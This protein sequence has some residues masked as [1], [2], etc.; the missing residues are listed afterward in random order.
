MNSQDHLYLRNHLFLFKKPSGHCLFKGPSSIRKG[1][2]IINPSLP[3]LCTEQEQHF[4]SFCFIYIL[5]IKNLEF[6]DF[7]KK[8]F[9]KQS[10]IHFNVAMN[11]SIK[12]AFE[13]R[14]VGNIIACGNL[15]ANAN[16][17]FKN[18]QG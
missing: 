6:K 7:K 17:N 8:T 18:L 5:S 12:N 11:T 10:K 14:T 13:K 2:R 4:G 16:W 1:N 15:L 9:E 3:D